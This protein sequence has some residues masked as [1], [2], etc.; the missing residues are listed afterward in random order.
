M[1]ETQGWMLTERFAMIFLIV[2]FSIVA[3]HAW[4]RSR[5]SAPTDPIRASGPIE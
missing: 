4:W 2:W 1:N 5:G 3:A